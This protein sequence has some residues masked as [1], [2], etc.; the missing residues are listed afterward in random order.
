MRFASTRGFLV[1]AATLRSVFVIEIIPSNLSR[2]EELE[3]RESPDADSQNCLRVDFKK[4][5][6]I[7]AEKAFF[8]AF[9]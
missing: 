1:R 6:L 2:F 7:L 5:P 9:D 3:I 8:R 4:G